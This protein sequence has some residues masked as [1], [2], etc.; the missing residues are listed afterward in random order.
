MDKI[1]D[2]DSKII[3]ILRFP[4]A[5]MIVVLHSM[6]VENINVNI[7]WELH[8]VP[9]EIAMF[10]ILR[11][12][13]SRV[14]GHIVVPAFMVISGY[15]FFVKFKN[16]DWL[17]YKKK[18]QSRINTLFIPYVLWNII[19]ILITILW[20]HHANLISD[21][22][23][24][25]CNKGILN[26]FWSYRGGDNVSFGKFHIFTIGFPFNVP[27]WFLRDLIIFTLIS[28]LIYIAIRKAF[29]SILLILLL[30][31]LNGGNA[32]I[33]ALI[34][35]YIGAGLS[36]KNISLSNHRPILRNII[37]LLFILN[38]SLKLFTFH[39]GNMLLWEKIVNLLSIMSGIYIVFML[40]SCIKLQVS[41]NYKKYIAS[42][43]FLIYVFHMEL[44]WR[45]H[46]FLKL[47]FANATN[48]AWQAFAV[49]LISVLTTI[50][51][52]LIINYILVKY[53]PKAN[54]ILT[55]NR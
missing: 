13:F 1:S 10:D 22:L 4:L 11:V 33:N 16:W 18:I 31:S 36:I 17:L 5:I 54:Y 8:N 35:F 21:Y 14:L 29:L 39:E 12:L 45:S 9:F 24:E 30:W 37:V 3:S 15:L 52:L 41:D 50:V 51:G 40:A 43:S 7:P 34:W 38:G 6:N 19:P 28:P 46:M 47:V 2:T 44:L 25:I 23:N 48:N 20:L 53:F 26:I 27:L 49:Y 55:A 32:D 42:S